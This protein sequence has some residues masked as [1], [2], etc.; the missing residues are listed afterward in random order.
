MSGEW[1]QHRVALIDG[2]NN[3]GLG[4]FQTRTLAQ[5]CTTV[6]L[7]GPSK[8]PKGSAQAVIPSSYAGPDARR[9]EA[10]K[11]RGR[12]VAIIVDVDSGNHTLDAIK[13]AVEA[14]I[15]GDVAY[16]VYSTASARLDDKKWRVFI[17]LEK[18]QAFA[19]WHD[20]C[21]VVYRRLEQ[22]GVAPDRA[23]KR[24]SQIS[25]LPNVP[26]E[27]CDSEGRPLFYESFERDG[28]GLSWDN[29]E[30]DVEALRKAV[31]VEALRAE[32]ERE[33]ARRRLGSVEAPRQHNVVAAFNASHS[34]ADSLVE[35]GYDQSP[36]DPRDFRSP[37]QTSG[38]YA[39]RIMTADDGDEFF[40]SLSVS[41]A[42]A[43]IGREA[44]SGCR[45]GDAFDLYVHFEHGGDF[46]AALRGISAAGGAA[47][48]EPP[49]SIPRELAEA[50]G[51]D[52]PPPF[53]GV[54]TALVE[55]ALEVAPKPQPD[56]T[57][58]A[59]LIGMASVCHG[60]Y[61]LPSGA[62]MNLFGL[63]VGNTGSGKDM[64][65]TLARILGKVAGVRQFAEAGS[66][67][68]IEDHIV[69][70][71]GTLLIIDEISSTLAATYAKGAPAHLKAA[72]AM[73]L[74]LFSASKSF[75]TTRILS[76]ATKVT[77]G[78]TV[79]H[80][81]VSLLGFATPQGLGEALGQGAITGGLLGR[82]LLA[83][84]VD[85]PPFKRS[86]A[87]FQLPDVVRHRLEQFDPEPKDPFDEAI[88]LVEVPD[89]INMQLDRLAS[90]FDAEAQSV[91]SEGERALLVRSFEKLERIA[92]VLAIW[93][94]PGSPVITGPMVEWAEALVRASD[95]AMLS[96][97]RRYMHSSTTHANAAR[98]ME[99]MARIL[100]GAYKPARGAWAP[101][102]AGGYAP[103]SMVLKSCRTIDKVS[104][105]TAVAHLVA[106]GDLVEGQAGAGRMAT[107]AF[108]AGANR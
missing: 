42:A 94:D 27:C 104:F 105:D 28:V 47:L 69:S 76:T 56:L 55:A 39:T 32:A 67:Q 48:I 91:A 107:L 92:G 3:R 87:S 22:T 84:A 74:K 62:R 59:A 40:T 8:L 17:P 108:P 106:Q 96:F 31:A 50:T 101:V 65:Q 78:R 100:S 15:G 58:L 54:M 1:Q 12:Y 5:V 57:L 25:F 30:E 75:Y 46:R 86:Q 21:E 60:R 36:K 6:A 7:L 23:M 29:I 66:G 77:S 16:W 64:P 85:A 11:A 26:P 63:G 18:P 79:D 97:V 102:I 51:P 41:D 44:K 90:A 20:G 52:M 61:A 88:Q 53:P 4:T 82:M 13:Q 35:Y 19:D 38:S 70:Y 83:R 103:R 24:A 2:Q 71:T 43:G 93:E 45:F 34:L 68:G 98:V 81:C 73:Y 9:A 95:G 49:G 37:L 80:P 89:R 10:Q 72:E 14:A 33:F 99:V